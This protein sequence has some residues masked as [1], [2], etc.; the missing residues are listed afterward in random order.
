ME[1]FLA[2]LGEH[3]LERLT[4]PLHLRVLIQP[5]MALLFGIRDGLKDARSGAPPYFWAIF[6]E[7]GH[8]RALLREGWH[9]MAKVFLI[10]LALDVL[11]QVLVFRAVYPGEAILVAFLL[12]MLPYM[13]I[14]GPINRLFAR[15]ATRT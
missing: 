8:R 13:L 1:D 6:T 15:W 2:R 5:G 11:Y 14:R 4:G 9:A 10:A 12:A 3:L 7:P